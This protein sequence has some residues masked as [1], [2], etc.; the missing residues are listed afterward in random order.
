MTE[1]ITPLRLKLLR[2]VSEK[3]GIAR[4]QMLGLPGVQPA[5]VDYL[6]QVDLIHEREVGT[7]RISHLGQMALKRM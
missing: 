7:Y 6:V 5:D 1:T 2:L 4:T 3:P